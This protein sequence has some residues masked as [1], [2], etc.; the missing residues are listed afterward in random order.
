MQI[1]RFSKLAEPRWI[2]IFNRSFNTFVVYLGKKC[3][4]I[5]KDTPKRKIYLI[6]DRRPIFVTRI[7]I[8]HFTG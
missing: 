4:C 7:H 3:I 1:S 5:F 6:P 2:N 8:D